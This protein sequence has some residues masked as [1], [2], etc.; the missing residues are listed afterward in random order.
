MK[1]AKSTIL[2]I[3]LHT[4]VRTPIGIWGHESLHESFP[5]EFVQSNEGT[6]ATPLVNC[7]IG[8]KIRK[9][10]VNIHPGYL[11]FIASASCLNRRGIGRV[12][13]WKTILILLLR[14]WALQRLVHIAAIRARL[15]FWKHSPLTPPDCTHIHSCRKWDQDTHAP[16]YGADCF[17]EGCP[18]YPEQ[19]EDQ[20]LE[21][22][23]K[24]MDLKALV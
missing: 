11:P 4:Y 14:T 18:N 6:A 22:V 5:P 15:A 10:S 17:H 3:F 9:N 20:D 19:A 12:H 24:S 2:F 13:R 8:A 16:C 23:D 1:R 21:Y 7:Q